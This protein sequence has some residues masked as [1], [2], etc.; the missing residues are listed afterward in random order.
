MHVRFR[1]WHNSSVTDTSPVYSGSRIASGALVFIS[2]QLPI[3]VD[4]TV[5]GDITSQTRLV[6]DNIE[7]ELA[8]HDLDWTAV[9][10]L[11]YFL[12]DINDLES[13]RDVL[14]ATLPQPRPAASLVEIGNLVNPHCRLE[15]EAVA[16]A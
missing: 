15:I 2:G 5:P 6:L 4:G 3:D 11:T 1:R 9:V 8:A 10:K 16:S 14:R 7:T 13:V 12:R